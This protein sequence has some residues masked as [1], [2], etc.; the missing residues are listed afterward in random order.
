MLFRWQDT[1]GTVPAMSDSDRAGDKE[2]GHGTSGSIVKWRDHVLSCSCRQQKTIAESS[3]APQ[4]PAQLLGISDALGVRHLLEEMGLRDVK[5]RQCDSRAARGAWKIDG[6]GEVRHTDLKHLGFKILATLER[7]SVGRVSST[8]NA[9]DLVAQPTTR[10]DFQRDRSLLSVVP[11][12]KA[13]NVWYGS[14][15][16]AARSNTLQ[17]S[18]E[19]KF[20]LEPEQNAQGTHRKVWTRTSSPSSHT[21]GSQDIFGAFSEERATQQIDTRQV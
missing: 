20:A 15:T 10:Q 5:R 1:T 4:F 17:R 19:D 18:L 8:Q 9:A 16:V 14:T 12:P 7:L 3:G 6:G 21:L 2:T 13:S 11:G